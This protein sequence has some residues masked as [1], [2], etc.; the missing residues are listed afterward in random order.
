M[1]EGNREEGYLSAE[2]DIAEAGTHRAFKAF[3][4]SSLRS[5]YSLLP[6][7]LASS[8]PS[9]LISLLTPSSSSTSPFLPSLSLS[10]LSASYPLLLL[11][12]SYPLTPS[13]S[14]FLLS[15][16]LFLHTFLP[17]F[18]PLSLLP[19]LENGIYIDVEVIAVK[20]NLK[21]TERLFTS[22][23]VREGRSAHHAGAATLRKQ[24]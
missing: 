23:Q 19:L 11:S 2:Q 10:V 12:P 13:F 8:R 16:S 1:S 7:P 3:L 6:Q 21:R 24:P 20:K 22:G 17:S 9:F 14:H 18:L 15:L 5:L 4:P